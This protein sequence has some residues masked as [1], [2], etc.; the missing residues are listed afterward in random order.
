VRF[1]LLSKVVKHLLYDHTNDNNAP[2]QPA[3]HT[4]A[5][6]DHGAEDKAWHSGPENDVETAEDYVGFV[7]VPAF[8]ARDCLG[9]DHVC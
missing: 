2:T 3:R 5:L 6:L 1:K 4:R 7:A 9:E 8:E